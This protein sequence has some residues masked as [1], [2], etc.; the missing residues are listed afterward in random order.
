MGS[1]VSTSDDVYSYGILL[2][3]MF[4]GKRP[5]DEM[6]SGGL[7]LHNF[8][9]ANVIIADSVQQREEREASTST[10]NTLN[11]NRDSSYKIQECLSLVFRIGIACSEESPT[12]RLDIIDVVAKLQITRN[13]LLGTGGTHVIRTN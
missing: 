4:T 2:L 5:T 9:K 11:Q 6:F 10:N 13:N 12:E 3:E 1:E 8:A 7:N